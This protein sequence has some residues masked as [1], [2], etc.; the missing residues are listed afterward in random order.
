M[1]HDLTSLIAQYRWLQTQH[2]A[3]GVLTSADG[4]A[5]VAE[6]LGRVFSQIVN[7]PSTDPRVSYRQ[8]AFLLAILA[9]APSTDAEARE[10]LCD[11]VLGH[12]KRL[13]DRATGDGHAAAGL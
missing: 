2:S 12:V 10:Y 4:D 5:S 13:A 1:S 6:A 8:I 3:N 9:D 11:A 7:Y